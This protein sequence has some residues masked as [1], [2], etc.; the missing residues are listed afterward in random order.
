MAN[1]IFD[2]P[3]SKKLAEKI[4]ITSPHAFRE[5]IKELKKGGLTL[6][7]KRGL[8]L[9]RTRATLQLKRKIL[10]LKERIQFKKIS[11]IKIPQVSK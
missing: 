3:K 2:P 10:S 5:S 4:S 9:A 1:G 11:M 8:V 6:Q 7:E